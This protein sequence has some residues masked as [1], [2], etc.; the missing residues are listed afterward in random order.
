MGALAEPLAREY[1]VGLGIVGLFTTSLFLVHSLVQI[2]GGRMADRFGPYPVALAALVLIAAGNAFALA[3]SDAALGI[4]A[5]ALAGLG[6]GAAFVAG[7]DYVR[8]AGGGALAQGVFGGAT[9]GGGGLALAVVPALHGMLDWRAP[10]FSACAVALAALGAFA[11]APRAPRTRLHESRDELG[12]LSRDRGLR[13]LAVVHM[14]SLGLNAVVA[15]WSV[16]LLVRGGG[17]SLAAAGL[18]SAL[19]LVAR[20]SA[21]ARSSSQACW[22]AAREPRCSCRPDRLPS[23][24]WPPPWWASARASRS[25]PSS[26][27]RP[28]PA[29]RARARPWGS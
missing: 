11:V 18:V 23:R 24:S 12:G 25:R 27:L 5:R 4:S 19:T 9:M 14:A 15:N 8:T 7:S 20:L 26:A 22:R 28:R 13:R 2:P 10:F 16:T 1:S 29:P 21:A 6:T 17:L 3:A